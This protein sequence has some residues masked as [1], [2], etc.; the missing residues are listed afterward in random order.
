MNRRSRADHPDDQALRR[1]TA[2]GA[3]AAMARRVTEAANSAYSSAVWTNRPRCPGAAARHQDH[4]VAEQQRRVGDRPG[5]VP[6]HQVPPQPPVG[7][8]GVEVLH[9]VGLGH[10]RQPGQVRELEPVRV[11]TAEPSGVERRSR[12]G[13][14]Q[15]RP[16]PVP[17]ARGEPAGVPAEA[18]DVLR[19]L[20]ADGTRYAGPQQLDVGDGGGVHLRSGL[21]IGCPA[22][23]SPS[24]CSTG[25]PGPP[26]ASGSAI[27]SRARP[28]STASHSS[29][30]CRGGIW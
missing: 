11:D 8:R 1:R 18:R 6:L 4:V 25:R 9:H 14:G 21:G 19:H 17:L 15:Q 26:R 23:Q 22:S 29:A 30:S 28:V 2:G 10:R 13:P 3:A 16:Q 7:G 20:A 24:R 5:Q 12:D 27:C